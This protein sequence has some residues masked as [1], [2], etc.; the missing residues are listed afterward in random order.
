MPGHRGPSSPL[1]R[2]DT[3]PSP[4]KR[5]C[6]CSA[7]SP[8]LPNTVHLSPA[9]SPRC[10]YS[11][12][13]CLRRKNQSNPQVFRRFE[14]ENRRPSSWDPTETK[15]IAEKHRKEPNPIRETAARSRMIE[16]W[17]RPSTPGSNLGSTRNSSRGRQSCSIDGGPGRGGLTRREATGFPSRRKTTAG[18]KYGTSGAVVVVV[19]VGDEEGVYAVSDWT[20]RERERGVYGAI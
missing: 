14:A 11:S 5:P 6:K 2:R 4:T 3:N 12:P 9:V 13:F 8:V 7:S 18:I 10:L 17:D 19:V 16:K 1:P 15:K 20:L